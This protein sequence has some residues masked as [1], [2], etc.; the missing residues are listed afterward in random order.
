MA[1]FLAWRAAADACLADGGQVN[2]YC[3]LVFPTDVMPAAAGDHA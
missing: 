2:T 3:T 1:H